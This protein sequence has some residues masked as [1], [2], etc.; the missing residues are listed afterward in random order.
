MPL[1]ISSSTWSIAKRF[2]AVAAPLQNLVDRGGITHTFCNQQAL[3]ILEQD[4]LQEQARLLRKHLVTFNQGTL[5]ADRGWKCFAHYLDPHSGRGLGCWPD[6]AGECEE[7]FQHALFYWH[8]G[9]KDLAIFYLGVAAHL[10]QDLCVPHHACGIAFNGHQRY[11]A[12]V[13]N[14]CGL[15]RI[16][17]GGYYQVASHAGDWVY[18]NARVARDYYP[19]VNT[20]YQETTRVLLGLAQRTTAGFV[21]HFLSQVT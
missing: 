7:Y 2:L 10:V 21:A 4:G 11:E 17:R 12:W 19:R 8:K 9:R 13:Q 14:H 1:V 5:W 20:D 6:A 3:D 16:S 18:T 15:F